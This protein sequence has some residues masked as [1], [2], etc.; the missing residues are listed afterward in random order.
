MKGAAEDK[1]E[2]K[3]RVD[4][5]D[6][7]RGLLVAHMALDHVGMLFNPNHWGH[8]F[9]FKQPEVP[10]STAQ[11][12]TRF[13]GVPV[14][15]GFFFMAGFMVALTSFRRAGR[16]ISEAQVTRRLVLRGLV[17]IGVDAVIMGLPRMAEGFAS[18]AVLSC[19]GSSLI[20]LAF[21]RRLPQPVLLGGTL[22]LI[23][24][25]PL[26]APGQLLD[27]TALPEPLPAIL[28]W[29]DREGLFRSLYP[30]MPWFS[31]MTLGFLVGRD[32]LEM[33]EPRRFWAGLAGLS[34]VAFFVLRW[35][36]LYGNA[37]PHYGID[38]LEFWIFAKYPPDLAWLTWSLAAIFGALVLLS[39]LPPRFVKWLHPFIDFGRVSFF[40]YIVHFYVIGMTKAATGL[41]L[42]LFQT[43]VAWL[44]LLLLLWWPCKW[45]YDK[46]T[47]RPNLLTRY[48]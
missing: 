33:P 32:S 36:M 35:T 2:R 17:L 24:I 13:S 22:V 14:A 1:A 30:L 38:S 9:A 5:V 42:S 27:I 20:L 4:Y 31:V 15:P 46:K 45:Y 40:F 19:I 21:L 44:G 7:F 34:L 18:M 12:L 23:G 28:Y 3:N 48:V 8:E 26:F 6:L 10:E 43:Y 47:K 41:E 25:H 11:F 37:Y 39:S 29:P 16:G